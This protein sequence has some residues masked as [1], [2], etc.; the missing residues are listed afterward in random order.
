MAWVSLII[1]I[2]IIMLSLG[3][4]RSGGTPHSGGPGCL[5]CSPPRL[6]GQ[7]QA[8]ALYSVTGAAL[9]DKE[10]WVNLRQDLDSPARDAGWSW[11][12]PDGSTLPGPPYHPPAWLQLLCALKKRPR[13]GKASGSLCPATSP[14]TTATPAARRPTTPTAPNWIQSAASGKIASVFGTSAATRRATGP[15]A[16]SQ[17]SCTPLFAHHE[18]H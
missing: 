9:E 18:S 4:R 5:P 11:T 12:L 17:A 2:I 8:T 15:C 7:A 14:T 3:G 16:S 1:I 6:C 13:E 10:F